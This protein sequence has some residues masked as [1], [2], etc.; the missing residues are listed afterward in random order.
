MI[1]PASQLA[2][3]FQAVKQDKHSS[4]DKSV[5]VFVANG[6]VDSLCASMQL[7]VG[8][9]GVGSTTWVDSASA[10]ALLHYGAQQPPA[11]WP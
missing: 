11:A 8:N 7:E 1:V 3:V 2:Q 10:R 5:L 6:D 9:W 4:E